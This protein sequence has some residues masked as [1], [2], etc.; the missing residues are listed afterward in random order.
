M[1]C[2]QK[3]IKRNWIEKSIYPPKIRGVSDERERTM[4][5][6]RNL[7]IYFQ[8]STDQVGR[9]YTTEREREREGTCEVGGRGKERGG[10]GGRSCRGAA[11]WVGLEL[12]TTVR[13]DEMRSN[14]PNHKR[15]SQKWEMETER[16]RREKIMPFR[17]LPLFLFFNLFGLSLSLSL[18]L[19]NDE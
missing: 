16:R 13:W 19:F 15:N 3:L 17:S 7:K 12:P 14:F 1:R 2:R 9:P 10:G 8:I 11:A 18:S 6:R 4:K 5:R